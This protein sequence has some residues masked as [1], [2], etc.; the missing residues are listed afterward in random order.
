LKMILT[1]AISSCLLKG[2]RIGYNTVAA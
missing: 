2:N 1:A